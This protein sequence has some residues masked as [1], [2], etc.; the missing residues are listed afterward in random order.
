VGH[1]LALQ[2]TNA[3]DAQLGFPAPRRLSTL[4]KRRKGGTDASSK[5]GSANSQKNNSAWPSSEGAASEE[6]ELPKRILVCGRRRQDR[7]GAFQY[8]TAG[9]GIACR[10][11]GVNVRGSPIIATTDASYSRRSPAPFLAPGFFRDSPKEVTR[12]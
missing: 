2:T 7:C 1:G 6:I 3:P 8:A 11:G 10:A 4:G 5:S 9:G 12:A